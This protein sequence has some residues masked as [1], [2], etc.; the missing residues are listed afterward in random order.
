MQAVEQ[1][2]LGRELRWLPVGRRLAA[3]LLFWRWDFAAFPLGVAVGAP[4]VGVMGV[5]GAL[6]AGVIFAHG[7]LIEG[8]QAWRNGF[9]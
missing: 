2:L 4:E 8:L 7:R 3:L 9:R 6:V 5:L 1:N